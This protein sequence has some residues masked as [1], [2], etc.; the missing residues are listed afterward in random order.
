MRVRMGFVRHHKLFLMVWL[1]AIGSM[2]PQSLLTAA[3]QSPPDSG[4][5]L[6]VVNDVCSD[7]TWG[8]SEAHSFQ[9]MADIVKAHLDRMTVTDSGLWFNRDRFTTTTTNEILSFLKKYPDR[10]DE[11]VERIKEGRL[12]LSPFLCN[13][14][15][16]FLGVEGFLRGLYPA[17]RLAREWRIPLDAGVHSE[18]P[19]FP[20]GVAA[21][22]PGSGIHWCRKPFLNDDAEFDKLTNPPILSE[23][24]GEFMVFVSPEIQ[25]YGFMDGSG[26]KRDRR[27]DALAA[28]PAM[29][30]SPF[31]SSLCLFVK[32]FLLR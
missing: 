30:E 3:P 4:W 16:G 10:R 24:G 6:Y 15:R 1:A 17:K 8:N 27:K 18:L 29:L 12:M 14:N 2:T 25:G 11:L 9:N 7:M 19:S 26:S 22:L 13:T 23:G 28:G 20:W 31:Y 5:T 21:L 32:T